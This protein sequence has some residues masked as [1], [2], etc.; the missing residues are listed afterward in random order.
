MNY[1][2][3]VVVQ[4]HNDGLG[5]AHPTLHV[6]K[7]PTSVYGRRR[8]CRRRRGLFLLLL[9]V[10][11]F[12]QILIHILGEIAKESQPLHQIRWKSVQ[13]VATRLSGGVLEVQ[14][15]KGAEQRGGGEE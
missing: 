9:A 8:R 12:R 5:R 7:G 4:L 14:A 15:T 1:L 3:R 11:S 2:E 6:D 10:A 13:T